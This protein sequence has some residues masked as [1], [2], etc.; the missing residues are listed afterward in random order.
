MKRAS[1]Q[2]LHGATA[3][4]PADVE[5]ESEGHALGNLGLAYCNL[6][7]YREAIDFCNQ[8]LTIKRSLGDRV[9]EANS[10]FNL[11]RAYSGL[12]DEQSTVLYCEQSLDIFREMNYPHGKTRV[13]KSSCCD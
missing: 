4:C 5:L 13:L 9:G 3:C 10:L 7:R 8:S 11:G 1:N 6:E 12:G 2:V